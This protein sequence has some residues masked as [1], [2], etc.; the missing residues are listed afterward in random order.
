VGAWFGTQLGGTAWLFLSGLAFAAKSP[1]SAAV[2]LGCG[3]AANVFGALLWAQRARLDPYRALQTLVLAIVLAGGAAT[4]WLELRGECELLD[5]RVGP[6]TMYVLLSA[7]WLGLTV[8]F[9][10]KGRAARKAAAA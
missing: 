9:A 7:M 4:R 3:L 2:L 5:S 6:H 1:L 10:V 8:L